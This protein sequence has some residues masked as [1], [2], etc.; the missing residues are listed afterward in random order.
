[1]ENNIDVGQQNEALEHLRQNTILTEEDWARFKAL[2]EK[3]YP[4]F[5]ARI[6]QKFPNLTSGELRFIAFVKLA[7]H[8]P[9]ALQASM[10]CIM[11]IT[12]LVDGY[13][14]RTI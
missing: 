11:N 5:F 6:N 9:T 10:L 3:A 12:P 1:M 14:Y 8:G 13:R 7:L 2:F 4:N